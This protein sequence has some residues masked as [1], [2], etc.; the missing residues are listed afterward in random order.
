[1]GSL[2]G[3][4]LLWILSPLALIPLTIIFGTQNSA[5]KRR[6]KEL[7]KP[8]KPSAQTTA[9]QPQAVPVQT[10]ASREQQISVPQSVPVQASVQNMQAAASQEQP[11]QVNAV[12]QQSRPVQQTV[13]TAVPQQTYAPP[14][15]KPRRKINTMNIVF[16]IGVLFIVVAGL[17]FAT[18]TWRIL[19]N[20]AK[21]AIIALLILLFFAA[22]VFARKK[23]KLQQTGLTFYSLGSLFI[24]LAFLGIGYFELLGSYLS[25]QGDGK[26]LLSLLAF[27]CLTAACAFGIKIYRSGLYVWLTY[28]AGTA[29]VVSLIWQVTESLD[30]RALILTLYCMA[31]VIL[32]RRF[33]REDR[34]FLSMLGRYSHI[35]Y[36]AVSLVLLIAFLADGVMSARCY[37][38]IALF[39]I[40][41]T[42]SYMI[43]VQE[44]R[45][46]LWIHPLIAGLI[47]IG[48]AN[49][50]PYGE[51][52]SGIVGGVLLFAVFLG[53]RFLQYR[54][55]P[56]FRNKLSDILFI[57]LCLGMGIASHYPWVYAVTAILC[58]LMLVV[59][60]CEKQQNWLSK[61]AGF[62]FPWST[63]YVLFS[64]LAAAY[65]DADESVFMVYY[66]FMMLF[67]ILLMLLSK[68]GSRPRRFVLPLSVMLWPCGSFMALYCSFADTRNFAP[69]YLW[70]LTLYAVTALYERI[71]DIRNRQERDTVMYSVQE[72][73]AS[74]MAAE[75]LSDRVPL[76]IAGIW[77]Y[78]LGVLASF[79]IYA[80]VFQLCE[81]WTMAE[82]LCIP[83]GI[84]AFT[85]VVF[86]LPMVYG[87]I[88]V[89]KEEIERLLLILLHVF[90]VLTTFVWGSEYIPVVWVGAF[91]VGM[92][93]LCQ[94]AL[95]WKKDMAFGFVSVLLF[96]I[97]SFRLLGDIGIEYGL[98]QGILTGIFICL[99][100]LGRWMYP[101]VLRVEQT[102]GK[103]QLY[104]DWPGISA[105]C[106]PVCLFFG[107]ET[108]CFIATFLFMIYTLNFLHR[109]SQKA[110]RP[111]VSVTVL[112]LCVA[113]WVQPFVILPENYADVINMLPLLLAVLALYKIVWR[114]KEHI[115]Y[116]VM[117]ATMTVCF[118][119]QFFGCV[120]LYEPT[121]FLPLLINDLI[122]LL[123][124]LAVTVWALL[125]RSMSYSIL[126]QILVALGFVC[127]V[128]DVISP[129]P[130]VEL[131][132]HLNL[133]L[134]AL[135]TVL[136]QWG[137]YR[138]RMMWSGIVPAG[139]LLL[140]FDARLEFWS[141][142]LEFHTNV[143]MIAWV[144]V[145]LSMLLLSY[146]LHHDR[147]VAERVE[148]TDVRKSHTK[149]ILIDWY[150][151]LSIYPTITLLGQSGDSAW[152]FIGLL[153]LGIYVMCFYHRIHK[154]LDRSIL[155]LAA[156]L[157][158]LM[159][160]TQPFLQVPLI[161]LSEWKMLPLVL[162]SLC[163]YKGIWRGCER[164]LSWVFCTVVAVCMLWQ[165]IDAIRGKVL[166][167]IMILGI[168][169]LVILLVSFWSK[170]KRWFLLA[171]ITLVTL[172]IYISKDFWLS[173]AWW[174]YLL[175]AGII[176]I[177][178]ASVNEY[179][180]KKGEHHESRFKR[181]MQE[182]E[183]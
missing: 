4:G 104:I 155:S 126:A 130:V 52:V 64:F 44:Q 46:M 144:L 53:Y 35:T 107:D 105:I 138:L 99:L 74:E 180:K 11:P 7:E 50:I 98:Q 101:T 92:V 167:D 63:I 142:Y 177:S 152:H 77:L 84:A 157:V 56:L 108:W 72:R 161:L 49:L 94:A 171:G 78:V 81:E 114:G 73:E 3:L 112:F 170:S 70:L 100:L 154:R 65:P 17:I 60:A 89:L 178:L 28:V 164:V 122:F 133:L 75:A 38:V 169:A 76:R 90:A 159:W 119:W 147:K 33:Q 69:V 71:V 149:G 143:I 79:S 39:C 67:T 6:L 117:Y 109:V 166:T 106:V 139:I 21:A 45:W 43:L 51:E 82:R 40:L 113:W 174:I 41:I 1:M 57:L 131:L 88:R 103:K 93:I 134:L 42:M 150:T 95:L 12:P 165:G 179:Y 55:K 111:I 163:L 160:W 137:L 58:M 183:W 16:I 18:T 121:D 8:Q 20:I 125:R 32:S 141:S 30:I 66:L 168:A 86:M 61:I 162:F 15:S 25:V 10:V 13:Y 19:P 59:L 176:L 127:A 22:S 145:F 85:L 83:M 36:Y 173:L 181:M 27:I 23:L 124:M 135:G 102:G 62:L 158:C 91:T 151:I 87:R 37:W 132:I 182:W 26:Y 172:V 116:W 24:P 128:T 48:A 96:W 47:V 34:A 175:A 129:D 120:Y 110:D 146:L 140:L 2:I 97:L 123:G 118:L 31:V 68:N 115:L 54:G 156:F 136:C 148:R 14:V 80:T 5:L 9:A 153:M 29:A